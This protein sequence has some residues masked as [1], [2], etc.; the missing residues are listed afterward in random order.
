VTDYVARRLIEREQAMVSAPPIPIIT[1]KPRR[2]PVWT[3]VLGFLAGA[4][5]LFG[6]ALI[7]TLRS[8]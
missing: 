2:S 7:A 8:L 6:L 3:F 1:D 4:A 5:A